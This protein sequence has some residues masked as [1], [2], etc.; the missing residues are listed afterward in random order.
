MQI[1][2]AP[3]LPSLG[4]DP[5]AADTGPHPTGIHV[6]A[7]NVPLTHSPDTELEYEVPEVR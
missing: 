6:H 2:N 1:E 7:G 5:P 3:Q 4:P